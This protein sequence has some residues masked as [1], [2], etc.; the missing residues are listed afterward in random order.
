MQHPGISPIHTLISAV[1]S[2]N[3][4]DLNLGCVEVSRETILQHPYSRHFYIFDRAYSWDVLNRWRIKHVMGNHFSWNL[5]CK[6]ACHGYW[7]LLLQHPSLQTSVWCS[8]PFTNSGGYW[9]HI[10][11][12]NQILPGEEV[13]SQALGTGRLELQAFQR[14]WWSTSLQRAFRLLFHSCTKSF[15]AIKYS[16]F[17][18]VC[19]SLSVRLLGGSHKWIVFPR[20]SLFSVRESFSFPGEWWL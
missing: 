11:F 5:H 8:V 20:P 7:T 14:A 13:C 9:N 1:R 15:V 6:W 2:S 12:F 18:S 3:Y 16:K 19:L 4:S 10:W 17:S